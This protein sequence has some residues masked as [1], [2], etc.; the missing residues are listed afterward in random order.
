MSA[1]D[2]TEEQRIILEQ[3]ARFGKEELAPN[4][5]GWEENHTFSRETFN[6]IA[7]RGWAGLF[8]S[9]EFGGTNQTRY[10]AA[11]I[12]EELGK[13]SF[14]ITA[15]LTVH[16]MVGGLIDKYGGVSQ[17]GKWIPKLTSGLMLGAFCLTEPGA[18]SDALAIRTRAIRKGDR[19]I[20]NGRKIFITSGGVADL[21]VVIAKTGDGN[22]AKD[23]TAFGLETKQEGLSFGLP[24]KKM[25]YWSSPTTDVLLED[26][27]VK[28]SQ[29]IGGE[30]QGFKIAM[31]A[32]DGGR[33]N[34]GACSVG[35][36]QAALDCALSYAKE[37][38]QF[39]EPIIKF[40]STQFKLA[41]MAIQIQAAR[42]M[43]G[44]A[45]SYMD[46]GHRDYTMMAAMAKCFASDVAMRVT[47][48]AV[49]ILG[50]Y[51]Y[52]RDFPVERYMRSAKL[53]QIVEGTNEIQRIIVARELNRSS[54]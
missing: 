9:E 53:T 11:L 34:I 6:R 24:E 19:Y 40:Q 37:R 8:C 20:L 13:H 45:A 25:G 41:D 33:I 36:A 18:G 54:P 14:S 2:L 50:G 12:F 43:V 42:L 29:R 15:P 10:N 27:E 31:S 39:G 7:E 52:M 48:E 5:Y 23:I 21:Y 49:Q 32:L 35:L 30:G 3:V 38:V 47:T 26:V 44:N 1:F 46:C 28:E 22:R 51:G 17:R 16:N 4:E